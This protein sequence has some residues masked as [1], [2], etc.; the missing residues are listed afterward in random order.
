[1][2]Q[3]YKLTLLFAAKKTTMLQLSR[4]SEKMGCFCV[5]FFYASPI[6]V[7]FLLLR[8]GDVG[9]MAYICDECFTIKIE[10]YDRRKDYSSASSHWSGARMG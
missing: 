5:I 7:Q 10:C 9:G 1:M 3:R 8:F 4:E 2:P 6:E